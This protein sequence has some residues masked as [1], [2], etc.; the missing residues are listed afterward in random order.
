MLA[1]G[2][3]DTGA[4][5]HSIEIW[6]LCDGTS[7]QGTGA[8]GRRRAPGFCV[9]GAT[10]PHDLDHGHEIRERLPRTR[11]G[12]GGRVRGGVRAKEE[13]AR[14]VSVAESRSRSRVWKSRLSR[15]C[16][17]S[18]DLSWLSRCGFALDNLEYHKPMNLQKNAAI[19]RIQVLPTTRYTYKYK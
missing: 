7:W 9:L 17:E 12:G 1:R 18:Q 3:G 8:R 15:S 16:P 10:A 11:A 6:L 13:R 2:P 4:G 14:R 19:R 5:A